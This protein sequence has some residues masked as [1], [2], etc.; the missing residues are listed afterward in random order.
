MISV[1]RYSRYY[2]FEKVFLTTTGNMCGY[3]TTL[4]CK[5]GYST[6]LGYKCGYSTTITPKSKFNY[7]IKLEI[8]VDRIS[9]LVIF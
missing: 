2:I 3:S 8:V 4:G 6:T 5:C 9:L 7:K 1:R